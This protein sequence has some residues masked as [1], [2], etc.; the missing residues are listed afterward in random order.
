MQ[1]E[2][3]L[4]PAAPP[5]IKHPVIL[6]EFDKTKIA[7]FNP[8]IWPST[9]SFEILWL[10][11]SLILSINAHKHPKVEPICAVIVVHEIAHG[12]VAPHVQNAAAQKPAASAEN[13]AVAPIKTP[14]STHNVSTCSLIFSSFE[15]KELNKDAFFSQYSFSLNH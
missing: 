7:I 11:Y 10:I 4:I 5:G 6:R 15:V 13:V 1:F 2:L 12:I 8:L 14:R 3:L 9:S